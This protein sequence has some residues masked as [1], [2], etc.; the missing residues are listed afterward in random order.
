MRL[1]ENRSSAVL[2]AMENR[3]PEMLALT[4]RMQEL[5]LEKD[6][7]GALAV[8]EEA[9]D[10]DAVL[11]NDALVICSH[12]RFL[13]D[14]E[15]VWARLTPEM[16]DTLSYNMM[17]K[18]CSRTRN[19]DRAEELYGEMLNSKVMP[20]VH[21]YHELLNAYAMS[22]DAERCQTFFD[23]LPDSLRMDNSNTVVLRCWQAV[24]TGW[25]REGNYERTRALFVKMVEAGLRP[26][27]THFNAMMI[28]CA[29]DADMATAQGVFDTM[30]A[31][32]IEPGFQDF[33]ILLSCSRNDL[34]RCRAIVEEMRARGLEPTRHTYQ[35]LLEAHVIAGDHEGGKAILNGVG[36]A[37]LDDN[38]KVRR[39]REAIERAT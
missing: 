12:G 30:L 9:S 1:G 39:L 7:R 25:G 20:N 6:W 27:V 18:L 34:T 2:S 29:R 14:G 23:S 38:V 21:T 37:V 17:M 13:S 31:W 22:G 19:V 24:M 35:E 16:K 3:S 15:R 36:G 4:S 33:N 10:P 5:K 8:F 28:A 26:G 32:K 11:L